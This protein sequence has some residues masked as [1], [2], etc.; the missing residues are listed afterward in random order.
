MSPETVNDDVFEEYQPPST[1]E[2]IFYYLF[3]SISG[4]EFI[5]LHPDEESIVKNRIIQYGLWSKSNRI[6]VF[7]VITVCGFVIW[8]GLL[9]VTD[10]ASAISYFNPAQVEYAGSGFL[11]I[12]SFAFA[13]AVVGNS[14]RVPWLPAE[15]VDTVDPIRLISVFIVILVVS[16]R[17]AFGSLLISIPIIGVSVAV[18][19]TGVGAFL[20][21]L[22][23]FIPVVYISGWISPKAAAVASLD[24]LDAWYRAFNRYE[25]LVERANSLNSL[26][27]TIPQDQVL[28]L[29]K[30][31]PRHGD[32]L[33]TACTRIEQLKLYLD[34]YEQ[35][36]N[37]YS[38]ADNIAD[39]D[40]DPKLLNLAEKYL[41]PY[42]SPEK[43]AEKADELHQLVE[44]FPKYKE[45]YEEV[46]ALSESAGCNEHFGNA[47]PE[48]QEL[49]NKADPTKFDEAIQQLAEWE[50]IYTEYLRLSD[51]LQYGASPDPDEIIELKDIG[52]SR[53][54]ALA[55][56]G[57]ETPRELQEANIERIA[58]V[59]AINRELA[60]DLKAR[61]QDSIYSIQLEDL[62]G[63][64]PQTAITLRSNNIDSVEALAEA[65][66]D[67]LQ[68]I[69]G[70][71]PKKAE[72]L[73][74]TAEY[75][76]GPTPPESHRTTLLNWHSPATSNPD[77]AKSQIGQLEAW[78]KAYERYFELR[79]RAYI[80]SFDFDEAAPWNFEHLGPARDALDTV[81][82]A[83]ECIER[84]QQF[85]D[86]LE[87]QAD[88]ATTEEEAEFV[89]RIDK[90]LRESRFEWADNPKT[91]SEK[92]DSIDRI[93]S[94]GSQIASI[95]E[96]YPVY[97]FEE[98]FDTLTTEVENGLK[99]TEK[100]GSISETINH[101]SFILNYLDIV[102][103]DHPSIEAEHWRNAVRT[104]LQEQYPDQLTPIKRQIER[105]KSSRWEREELDSL[106]WEE[107]ESIVGV[108]FEERGFDTETTRGSIDLGVDVWA[109]SNDERIA[110]QAK[111]YAAG[112]TVGRE[113]LQKLTSTLA[114]GDA[115]RAVVVTSSSFANTAV[116]YADDFGTDLELIDG[117]E[118]LRELSELEIPPPA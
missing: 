22:T 102:E 99:S 36:L 42:D 4:I 55:E 74:Q 41:R 68:S 63:V 13:A 47:V 75:V 109:E 10:L 29:S 1:V 59:E 89:N 18:G 30:Y 113:T 9:I 12:L 80:I 61:V 44:Q 67:N 51:K 100:I 50:T 52:D 26:A 101:S 85:F 117:D 24:E 62:K 92:F 8:G 15:G 95:Q 11:L 65:S 2:K 3:F 106:N 14:P 103:T 115:D 73:H 69:E 21:Y 17:A 96:E 111:H 112:N 48:P 87:T 105:L 27:P 108:L 118:F 45:A 53:R 70:I 60:S 25:E 38:Q 19:S 98:I 34:S 97:P 7:L 16:I 40:S 81:E 57:I 93:L 77:D 58:S 84:Y 79:H 78:V 31:N 20:F 54:Q 32:S 83:I 64:G 28:E 23:L 49:L 35:I 91:I 37:S 5:V 46:K 82:H 33:E 66:A 72:R 39:S 88:K 107:F 104:A 114:K 86:D 94:I 56:V 90:Y 71:G 43:A 76:I 6:K 110:I 116:R